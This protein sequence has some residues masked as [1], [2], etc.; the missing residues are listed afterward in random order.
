LEL[1]FQVCSHQI[2]SSLLAP[3]LSSASSS[4]S[5]T[6]LWA[7]PHPLV[8]LYLCVKCPAKRVSCCPA[9]HDLGVSSAL[10]FSSV[11]KYL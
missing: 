8:L 6:G 11:A 10:C 1:S 4:P 3:S 9:S 5:L 2:L 7:R